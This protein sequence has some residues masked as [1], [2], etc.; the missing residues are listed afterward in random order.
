MRPS[1]SGAENLR[2]RS[3][4]APVLVALWATT[5]A[6]KPSPTKPRIQSQGL[7]RQGPQA[8]ADCIPQQSWF[9][10]NHRQKEHGR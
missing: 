7:H 8:D 9:H 1:R 4:A 2:P 5:G 6:Q 3:V 10:I